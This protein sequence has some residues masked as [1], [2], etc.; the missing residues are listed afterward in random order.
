MH[1][2]T[3]GIN[4]VYTDH[5]LFSFDDLTCVNINKVLKAYLTDIDQTISVSN[6]GRENLILRTMI[7]PRITNV[8]PNSV[9]ITKFKP[10]IYNELNERYFIF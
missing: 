4:C 8:I 1:A 2:K 7:D 6:L 9:D 3:L 5:S 10:E